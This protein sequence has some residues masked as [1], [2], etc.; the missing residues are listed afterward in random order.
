MQK[1]S[2]F[3]CWIPNRRSAVAD[4]R[5]LFVRLCAAVGLFRYGILE[6]L[7]RKSFRHRGHIVVHWVYDSVPGSFIAR[8]PRDHGD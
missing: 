1:K 5:K 6:E 7:L 8:Q 4:S 3:E 2:A